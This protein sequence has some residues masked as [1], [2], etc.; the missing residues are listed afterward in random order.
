MY[1]L[2]FDVRN[3]DILP[4]FS[5]QQ[6]S[7]DVDVANTKKKTMKITINYLPTCTVKLGEYKCNY[8][9]CNYAVCV[10]VSWI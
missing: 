1:R 10:C 6:L 7:S 9:V 4:S 5:T 8:S 2:N 3:E